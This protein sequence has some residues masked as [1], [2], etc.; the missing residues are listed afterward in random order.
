MFIMALFV[1]AR[2]QNKSNTHQIIKRGVSRQWNIIQ[3]LKR[4]WVLIHA[5]T[6]INFK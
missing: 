1:T 6:W 3:Q 5:M 2:N 4:N